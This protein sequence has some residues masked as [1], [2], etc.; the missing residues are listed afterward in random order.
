M[1]KQEMDFYQKITQKKVGAIAS[2]GDRLH[3]IYSKFN[4][5]SSK[6]K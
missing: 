5:P 4:V 6:C 1:T 3:W 2:N